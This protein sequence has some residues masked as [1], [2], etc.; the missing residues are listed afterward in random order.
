MRQTRE[1]APQAF[2]GFATSL[3]C[4]ECEVRVGPAQAEATVAFSVEVSL[5]SSLGD[6]VVPLPKRR[7]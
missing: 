6:T 4:F 5:E 1:E 3:A 7:I 2:V